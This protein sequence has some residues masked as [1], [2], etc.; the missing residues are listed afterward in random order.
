[1]P[2]HLFASLALTLVALPAG[3]AAAEDAPRVIERVELRD[4]ASPAQLEI[5][6]NRP[7]NF[8]SFKLALPPRIVVDFP[9]TSVDPL[10][11]V[12]EEG[13]FARWT[14]AMLGKST[15]PTARL[16]VELREDADYTLT[17]DGTRVHLGLLPAEPRVLA[18]A[19]APV[20]VAE[21][22]PPV[23]V[24]AREPEPAVVVAPESEPEPEPEPAVVVAPAAPQPRPVVQAPPRPAAA[25]S[26][27][28][29]VAF[30]RT[31][32]GARITLRTSSPAAYT[33]LEEA[34]RLLLVL[35]HASIPHANDRRPLD[36]RYFQ[37]PVVSVV[38]REDRKAR[39]VVVEVAVS[40]PVVHRAEGTDEIVLFVDRAEEPL[41][42]ADQ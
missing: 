2:K 19:A 15:S 18:Q 10:A 3:I 4:G 25:A 16:V 39:R 33:V 11:H 17:A 42:P 41:P 32:T 38:P 30:G 8:T 24:V 34:D 14:L 23:E 36:T 12:V 28:K 5:A 35:D 13:P 9:E 22:K 7:A 37:T 26:V 1:M 27:V 31:P 40:G 29:Q 20:V 6:T 21:P